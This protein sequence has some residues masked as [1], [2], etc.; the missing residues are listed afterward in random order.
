ML[1]G[2]YDMALLADSALQLPQRRMLETEL[3]RARNRITD[4]LDDCCV[5]IDTTLA[6][7]QNR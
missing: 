7:D 6:A 3:V 5:L 1:P 4:A 2:L